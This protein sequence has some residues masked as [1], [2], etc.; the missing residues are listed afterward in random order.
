[1]LDGRVELDDAYLCGERSGG[2]AGRGSENKVPFV[3][4]VQTTPAGKPQ[5]VCLRQQPFTHEEVASFAARSIGAD[6]HRGLRWA[7]VLRLG[8]AGRR[9]ARAHRHRRRRPVRP[10]SGW[11]NLE[12]EH[13]QRLEQYVSARYPTGLP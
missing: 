8:A 9:R 6:G 1:M 12:G 4:A 3:A 13:S 11:I 2:R 7:V 5:L 10:E